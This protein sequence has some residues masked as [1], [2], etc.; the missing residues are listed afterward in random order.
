MPFRTRTTV[1]LALLAAV[2]VALTAC[3]QRVRLEVTSSSRSDS[4]VFAVRGPRDGKPVAI[5]FVLVKS[6]DASFGG[7]ADVYWAFDASD[8]PSDLLTLTYGVT[9]SGYTESTPARGLQRG[10]CYAVAY[11]AVSYTYVAVDSVG[12]VLEVSRA[13][14][15]L[16]AASSK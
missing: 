2:T 9:P 10:G 6:C 13:A 14:A 5:K 3:P 11:G 7:P 12:L 15:E 16:R 1:R 8:S 4:L